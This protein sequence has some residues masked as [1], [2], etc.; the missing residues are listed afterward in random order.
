[1]AGEWIGSN[2]D[3]TCLGLVTDRLSPGPLHLRDTGG[4]TSRECR[5]ALHAS[6]IGVEDSCPRPI[7][8]PKFE[9]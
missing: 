3:N 9:P 1:M 2:R 6:T 8:H 5:N 4:H 7:Q